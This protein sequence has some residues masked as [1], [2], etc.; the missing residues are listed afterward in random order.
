MLPGQLEYMVLLKWLLTSAALMMAVQA[1]AVQFI[2]N[3]LEMLRLIDVFLTGARQITLVQQYIL[4]TR[5]SGSMYAGV[6]VMPVNR[7]IQVYLM[8]M[9]MI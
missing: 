3:Q 1:M 8:Y 2:L 4:N 7:G 9:K 5:N 6:N